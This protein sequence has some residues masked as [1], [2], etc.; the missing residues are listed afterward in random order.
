MT[1][2]IAKGL[3]TGNLI[4]WDGPTDFNVIKHC[5]GLDFSH[6]PKSL[7][8][9][10]GVYAIKRIGIVDTKFIRLELEGIKGF[11]RYPLVYL[12]I[13]P[14]IPRDTP[15]VECSELF[16]TGISASVNSEAICKK[17]IETYGRNHQLSK[18]IEELNELAVEIAHSIRDIRNL[19]DVTSEMADVLITMEQVKLILG[20][21]SV[22]ID[23][24]IT[25]KLKRLEERLNNENT[26]H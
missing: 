26:E 13:V 7:I 11:R 14:E 4:S 25:K 18:A 19:D 5:T 9:K 20:I 12:R 24:W 16:T 2:L 17:A 21:Q 10:E 23:A 1:E 8:V 6:K 3:K 15:S 22:D